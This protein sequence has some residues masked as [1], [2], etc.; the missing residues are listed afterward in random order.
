MT[1]TNCIA[2][3]P[4]SLEMQHVSV[5]LNLLM[6]LL[7]QP[8][9]SAGQEV[10]EMP[11]EVMVDSSPCSSTCGLGMKTQTL[12]LLKDSRTVMEEDVRNRNGTEVSQYKLYMRYTV[13]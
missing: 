1:T 9:T 6:V 8:L 5:R 13:V 12:C 11:V 4:S 2:D 7:L 3:L 10:N